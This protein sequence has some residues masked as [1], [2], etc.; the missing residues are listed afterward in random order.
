MSRK[1]LRNPMTD[2]WLDLVTGPA[3]L[4]YLHVFNVDKTTAAD[5]ALAVKDTTLT[6]LSKP[7][8]G[9]VTPTG[10]TGSTK[11]EYFVTASNANGETDPLA[12]TIITDGALALDGTT[13]YHTITWDA[14][15]GSTEYHVYV[16]V[17]DTLWHKTSTTDTSVVN[18]GTWNIAYAPPWL[19]M[20]AITC[21]LD[22]ERLAIGAILQMAM[23][24]EIESTEKIVFATSNSLVNVLA[25]YT[26][27]S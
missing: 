3:I 5:I 2:A 7:A 9:T 26:E 22:Y 16:R 1:L 21:L 27:V 20:T 13:N 25:R 17:S 15:T 23:D 24:A 14:V 19:N 6:E 18:D 4:N 12:L 10:D 8:S 11:Y